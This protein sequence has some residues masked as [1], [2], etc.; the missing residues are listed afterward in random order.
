MRPESNPDE[1]SIPPWRHRGDWTH[2]DW[3]RRRRFLFQR[4]IRFVVAGL[5]LFIITTIGISFLF[6]RMLGGNFREFHL[7]WLF[8]ILLVFG[9]PVALAIFAVRTFSRALNPLARVMAAADSVAQGDLTVQVPEVGPPEFV[10]LAHSFNHMVQELQRLDQ[11]RRNLMADVAHELRTPL[12]IL[13]GNIEGMQDG[14]YAPTPEQ[15]ELLLAETNQL[16]RLIEDLRTLSLAEAGQLTLQND[17][18][19]VAEL[20]KDTATSFLGQVEAAGIHLD[21]DL[22]THPEGLTVRGDPGRLAQVLDNLVSNALRHTPPGG[23]I[24]LKAC[25]EN[26]RVCIQVSDNGKG[27]PAEDLPNIFDR[28]WR[29]NAS[30]TESTGLGLA[31]ARQLVQSHGG[32]IA[33]ESEPGKG[34]KFTIDLPRSRMV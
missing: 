34:A 13:Q 20:L 25:L 31:I 30:R 4:F 16:S 2:P 22:P 14:V 7:V 28:F 19:S 11:L 33:V 26:D 24:G 18:I 8:G 21:L 23:T 3:R 5:I 29:G 6:N 15:Y 27:I 1:G 9:I 17:E 10:R 12:H 32:S